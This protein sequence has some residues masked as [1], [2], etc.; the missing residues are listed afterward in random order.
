MLTEVLLPR[1]ALLKPVNGFITSLPYVWCFVRHRALLPAVDQSI[2]VH[3][4]SD[5]ENSITPERRAPDWIF[6]RDSLWFD[7]I[8]SCLLLCV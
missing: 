1:T 6:S 8:G 2:V 3:R 4:M 5:T 7:P